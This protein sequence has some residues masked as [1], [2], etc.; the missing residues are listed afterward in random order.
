MQNPYY[1]VKMEDVRNLIVFRKYYKLKSNILWKYHL[2][3]IVMHS[4]Y[5]SMFLIFTNLLGKLV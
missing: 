1:L 4:I 3:K 5:L 2:I